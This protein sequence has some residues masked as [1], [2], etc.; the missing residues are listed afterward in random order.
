ME[1]KELKLDSN[2]LAI[3]FVDVVNNLFKN[4]SFDCKKLFY[5]NDK[6]IGNDVYYCAR[7]ILKC[8][9]YVGNQND[10]FNIISNLNNNCKFTISELESSYSS[11]FKKRREYLDLNKNLLD[12]LNKYELEDIY[13][14]NQGLFNLI[15]YF[16]NDE[17]VPFKNFI[18]N[19]F[20]PGIDN[21]YQSIITRLK[22][23]INELNTKLEKFKNDV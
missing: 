21:Q 6:Y 11:R 8:L 14:N 19:V 18:Y 17:A 10:I 22:T 7:D 16:E 1:D 2:S 20:L 9:N 13:I 15:E 5:K 23:R 12:Y 4:N 3:E